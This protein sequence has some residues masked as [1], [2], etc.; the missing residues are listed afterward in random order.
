M[1]EWP[2][3]DFCELLMNDL[4]HTSWERRHGAATGLREIIKL[5]GQG[6]GRALDITLEK[7]LY[8]TLIL[9]AKC[10]ALQSCWRVFVLL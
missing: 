3:E 7:V 5:H 4:F 1:E 6:A 9:S 2:F 8:I 10:F